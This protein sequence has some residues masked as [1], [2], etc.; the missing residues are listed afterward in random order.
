[1][2]REDDDEGQEEVKTSLQNKTGNTR[3]ESNELIPNI[4]KIKK[5]SY[6]FI[7][8]IIQSA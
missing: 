1:M 8:C 6:Y 7:Y 3:R 4:K 2:R 5:S